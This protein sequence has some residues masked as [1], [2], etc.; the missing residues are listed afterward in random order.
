MIF[1]SVSL[2]FLSRDGARHLWSYFSSLQTF[3]RPG[4]RIIDQAGRPG[5]ADSHIYLRRVQHKPVKLTRI[6]PRASNSQM[7]FLLKNIYFNALTF[8]TAT[9]LLKIH[10]QQHFCFTWAKKANT[11]RSHT[12]NGLIVPGR[13]KVRGY[14]SN[15]A[16]RDGAVGHN[17]EV[18]SS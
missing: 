18:V 9:Q 1:C 14:F 6:I 16:T 13:A 11:M 4:S 2:S 7:I 12:R 8:F 17:V 15:S 5:T 3:H 10:S